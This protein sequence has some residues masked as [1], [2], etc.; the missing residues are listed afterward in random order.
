MFD[1]FYNLSLTHYSNGLIT[2]LAPLRDYLCPRD[3]MASPLLCTAKELYFRR[4]SVEPGF[5]E[6]RRITSEDVNVEHLLD[7]FT[8]IDADSEDVWVACV[9]F[10]EHLF[11]H[12]PRPVILGSKFEAL[13]DSHPSKPRCLF[14]LSSLLS[15]VGN[16]REQKRILIQ[17]LRLWKEREDDDEVAGTLINLANA[18]QQLDL[19]EE[20][21]EQAREALNIFRQ[22]N[23]TYNQAECL[24][25][26]A[27]L[28]CK[29][30]QLDAAEEAASLA[31]GLLGNPDQYL[32]CQ[33]RK[34]LGEIQQTK[35][36][37]EHAIRHFEASL[38]HLEVSLRTASVLNVHDELS[39]IHLSLADFY[40]EEGRIDDAQAHVEH[41]KSW[42]GN[43]TLRLGRALHTSA[44][45]LS[46]QNRPEE[47]KSEASRALAI[48]EKL[49][50]TELVDTTRELLEKIGER[51]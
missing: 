23:E 11:W 26:L 51:I 8:S 46:T 29:D 48:L 31:M 28:L 27:R 16:W 13:P 17:T 1:A 25:I 43:D 14:P 41:A 20:G 30:K 12:K 4:L 50:T 34:V 19:H 22:L 36:N 32:L 45:I 3:L 2:M 5:Y 21:I 39:T 15:I 9:N 38:R 33:C 42:A 35:G 6:S 24:V 40:F 49:G 7:V 37:R 10:M 47:A 18:N 44:R